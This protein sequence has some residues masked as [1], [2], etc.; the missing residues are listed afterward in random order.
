RVTV[1]KTQHKLQRK[2]MPQRRWKKRRSSAPFL[3]QYEL[4]Q[5]RWVPA[6]PCGSAESQ[7]LVGTPLVICQ[8]IN[9]VTHRGC[10]LMSMLLMLRLGTRRSGIENCLI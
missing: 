6:L 5:V 3:R 4:D 8:C 2:R 7:P 10:T 9:K 1:L